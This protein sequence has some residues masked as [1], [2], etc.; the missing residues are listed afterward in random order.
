MKKLIVLLFILVMV[1]PSHGQSSQGRYASRITPDGTIFFINPQK[2]GALTNLRQFEYDMTLLSW[3]DSVTINFTIESSWMTA[4]ENFKIVSDNRIYSCE[5]FSV[6]FTDIKKQH[7]V[8]R[9]TSK[10]SLQELT[11]IIA[12]ASS[13][14]FAFTQN[15]V[16]EAAK[17]TDNAWKKE[18]KKL[19]AIIQLYVY[20]KNNSI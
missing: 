17:Y 1:I 2:L 18:R 7:Y 11:Q 19:L 3:K 12:S 4:P 14:I 13:P 20:S 10:F 8:I 5:D 16:Q 6:L 15:G 9:I